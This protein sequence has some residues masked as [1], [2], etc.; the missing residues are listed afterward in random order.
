MSNLPTLNLAD[1]QAARLAQ[2][3]DATT[4]VTL[5]EPEYASLVWLAGFEADTVAHVTA[6]IRRARGLS[7]ERAATA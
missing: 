2:L 5:T 6:I 4:G 1:W 7:G 3:L